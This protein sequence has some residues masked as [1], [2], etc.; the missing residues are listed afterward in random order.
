MP[1]RPRRGTAK[2]GKHWAERQDHYDV[3]LSRLTA[4]LVAAAQIS[5]TDQV[6]DVGCRC[7]ETAR[8]AAQQASKGTVLGLDLSGPMLERARAR[9]E[10][11]GL[12]NVRRPRHSPLSGRR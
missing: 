9:A 6:L 10:E 2:R 3:M 11:E 5:A 12:S 1:S 8:I 7:G 4:R